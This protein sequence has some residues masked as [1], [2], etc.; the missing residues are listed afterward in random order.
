ML[1]IY[2]IYLHFLFISQSA[3]FYSATTLPH[4]VI[5]IDARLLGGK[6]ATDS[7]KYS[8]W[9]IFHGLT[10]ASDT[11]SIEYFEQQ[12]CQPAEKLRYRDRFRSRV[13]ESMPLSPPLRRTLFSPGEEALKD[14]KG[15]LTE[16]YYS[17]PI[18]FIAVR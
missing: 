12:I 11:R 6:S 2:R 8:E 10:L 5:Y 13:S 3:V 16:P 15:G 4:E 18:Y 1:H 7:S 14:F 9:Q 17:T